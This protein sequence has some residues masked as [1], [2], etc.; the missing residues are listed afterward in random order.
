VSANPKNRANT[1]S[2]SIALWAAAAI[3]LVGMIV[4]IQSPKPVDTVDAE[5]AGI[6]ARSF[7][8]SAGSRG[9]NES[10][11]GARIATNTA[12]ALSSSANTTIAR[13]AV[14]PDAAASLAALT[15]TT[16]R[17]N[18]SGTTVICSALSQSRPI[19]CTTS[20]DDDASIGS[21]QASSNPLIAPATRPARMRPVGDG[22]NILLSCVIRE[23]L[24]LSCSARH[25]GESR[26]PAL[27]QS[28]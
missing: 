5:A 15:P 28:D 18:T 1:T 26:D 6:A 10:S 7:S 13:C 20:A 4:A 9:R 25:P 16:T 27:R 17:A 3:A 21:N 24:A 22:W 11:S 23:L 12:P 19:G 8:M 2:G 14:R